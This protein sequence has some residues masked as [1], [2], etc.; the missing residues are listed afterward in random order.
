MKMVGLVRALE[1]EKRLVG[2]GCLEANEG[3][4]QCG[5]RGRA[6]VH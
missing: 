5:R 3:L 1:L 2:G 4:R 6:R